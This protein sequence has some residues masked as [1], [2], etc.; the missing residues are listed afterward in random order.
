M[1]KIILLL[2]ILL[3]IYSC[4]NVNAESSYDFSGIDTNAVGVDTSDFN[5]GYKKEVIYVDSTIIKK[6]SPLFK[7]SIDEFSEDKIAWYTPKSAPKFR[8]RNGFY[9]YFSPNNFRLVLQYHKDNWLFFEKCI[10]LIDGK[11]YELYPTDV[12]RDNDS[13]GITEWFDESISY[14]N[15]DLIVMISDAK[16]VKIKLVGSQYV[17]YVNLTN[18]QIK[19]IKNTYDYYKALGYTF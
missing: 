10:F 1:K 18:N 4:K 7:K 19:S 9:C 2:F 3:F 15:N 13:S 17:D 5:T 11:T 16:S 14:K 8:N 6:L 12:K